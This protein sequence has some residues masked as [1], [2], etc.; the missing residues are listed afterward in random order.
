MKR[1]GKYNLYKG[2][3]T[4]LTLGTPIATLASCSDLF[5]HRSDTAVSAAG[6]FALLLTALFMKDKL[7]ENLKVP[8]AFVLSGICLIL[9]LMVESIIQPLKYVCITTLCVSG[10]D[11][12][13]F[14]RLYKKIEAGL[15]DGTDTNKM[16][17]FM[18]TT[19]YKAL[20]E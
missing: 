4:L 6:I 14:K 3:S 1:I 15:P 8:S 5:V 12:L 7:A 19:T 18:F 10:L 11:E 2:I 20:G 16:F 17:G 9:L 13:T